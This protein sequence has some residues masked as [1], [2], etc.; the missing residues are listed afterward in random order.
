MMA[1]IAKNLEIT[2]SCSC[3]F[4]TLC[5]LTIS[6]AHP[7]A[8]WPLVLCLL[9]FS[10]SLLVSHLTHRA[11]PSLPE[12][13]PNPLLSHFCINQN[14]SFPLLYVCSTLFNHY[15][16]EFILPC[17]EINLLHTYRFSPLLENPWGHRLLS[18][19]VEYRCQHPPSSVSASYTC[20]LLELKSR[21]TLSSAKVNHITTSHMNISEQYRPHCWFVKGLHAIPNRKTTLRSPVKLTGPHFFLLTNWSSSL[22]TS[23]AII[24]SQF[25]CALAPSSHWHPQT[26][27]EAQQ[28]K[29]SSR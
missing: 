16:T 1:Y 29:V 12:A 6:Q 10:P 14:K 17:V 15:N 19:F 23:L 24:L 8:S 18:I 11:I 9:L 26:Q 25:S 13:F 5:S 4:L 20:S 7:C 21:T 22:Q 2:V 27:H 3:C 28:N